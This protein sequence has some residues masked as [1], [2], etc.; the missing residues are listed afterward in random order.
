MMRWITI[1]LILF[2]TSLHAQHPVAFATTQDFNRIK[3]ALSQLPLLQKTKQDLV[4]L[5][6]PYLDKMP[7]ILLP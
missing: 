5:V 1:C 2:T 3:S 4:K 7:D 6:E